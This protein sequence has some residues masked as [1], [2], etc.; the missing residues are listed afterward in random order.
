MSLHLVED[1]MLQMQVT[2]NSVL[3]AGGRGPVQPEVSGRFNKPPARCRLPAA[4]RAHP[5]THPPA[6]VA[7][8]RLEARPAAGTQD[9]PCTRVQA[10]QTQKKAQEKN[11]R[12]GH[13]RQ[14]RGEARC[15]RR[16]FKKASAVLHTPPS[17]TPAWAGPAWRTQGS[18]F[19][20]SHRCACARGSAACRAR[21][22]PC[23]PGGRPLTSRGVARSASRASFRGPPGGR[24]SRRRRRR[25]RRRGPATPRAPGAACPAGATRG[26][27]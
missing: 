11:R 5:A 12:L 4:I 15:R 19:V 14:G 13:R 17:T 18:R 22:L 25:R 1:F 16:L 20:G 26:R 9:L 8:R 7:K 21:A 23:R 3:R 6:H 10:P 24:R 27:S 2:T